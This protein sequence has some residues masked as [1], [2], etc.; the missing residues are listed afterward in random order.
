MPLLFT[1]LCI[2]LLV[3]V[4]Y[5]D[6]RHRKI[7]LYLF[8]ILLVSIASTFFFDSIF[9]GHNSFLN[10]AINLVFILLLLIGGGIYF[11]LRRGGSINI[12]DNY[13][14]KGDVV[15]LLITS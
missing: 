2:A 8:L 10:I 1:S 4:A 3:A 14:G 13:I 12:L 15:F 9:G 6:F 5:Q 11:F 7:S